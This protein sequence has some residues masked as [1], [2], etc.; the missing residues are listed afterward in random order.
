M[1]SYISACGY[2]GET[3]FTN[4][5]SKGAPRDRYGRVD[6]DYCDSHPVAYCSEQHRDA[7]DVI[8]AHALREVL[9]V[10]E[11]ITRREGAAGTELA[12]AAQGGAAH[13]TAALRRTTDATLD[14]SGEEAAG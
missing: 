8:R 10:A 14:E 3:Q 4:W 12:Q 6:R 11:K 13:V 1:S 2:C 5:Y 7:A 9:T